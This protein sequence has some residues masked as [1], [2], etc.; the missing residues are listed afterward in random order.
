MAKARKAT[1]AV[2]GLI[3]RAKTK[4]YLPAGTAGELGA[5]AAAATRELDSN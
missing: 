3:E 4:G 2:A 1:V 5:L